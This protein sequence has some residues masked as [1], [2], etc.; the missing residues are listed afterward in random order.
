MRYHRLSED[1]R[2]EISRQLAQWCSFQ[3]IALV[4]GRSVSTISR[5]VA[6]GGS[7]RSVYRA[8]RAHRRAR[9]K[10]KARKLSKT[11]DHTGPTP[12]PLGAC[13]APS[14]LVSGYDCSQNGPG[15]SSRYHYAPF[16]RSHVHVSLR[17]AQRCTQKRT[18]SVFAA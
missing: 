14:A 16:S 2:E 3:T 4:L 11:K 12:A 9:R 6:A 7:N 10:A 17:L 15:V 8:T 1:E 18:V 5:E 13:Q